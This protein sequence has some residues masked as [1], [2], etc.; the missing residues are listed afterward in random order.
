MNTQLQEVIDE[1]YVE[2]NVVPIRTQT[3]LGDDSEDWLSKLDEGTVFL[4]QRNSYKDREH[5]LDEYSL[6]VKSKG[7]IALSDRGYQ[8]WVIPST[9][10][11]KYSL[12]GV[13]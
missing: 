3:D 1:H 11:R 12:F 8:I 10:C 4:C 6:L 13:L 7:A 9:F 5:I 2:S